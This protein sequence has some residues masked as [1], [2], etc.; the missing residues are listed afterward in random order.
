[1]ELPPDSSLQNK[2]VRF[3]YA[4]LVV[5]FSADTVRVIDWLGSVLF[6]VLEWTTIG[7]SVH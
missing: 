6:D 4:A 7:L 5:I 1:M 2:A 3:E